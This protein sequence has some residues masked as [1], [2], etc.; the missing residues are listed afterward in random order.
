MKYG[1][2]LG[3]PHKYYLED[4]RPTHFSEFGNLEEAETAKGV[5]IMRNNGGGA[6]SNGYI[7]LLAVMACLSATWQSSP[8]PR[9]CIFHAFLAAAGSLQRSVGTPLC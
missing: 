8:S 2:K 5:E 3:T 7:P 9:C 1:V 6:P 4:H